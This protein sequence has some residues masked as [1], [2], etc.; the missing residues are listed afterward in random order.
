MIFLFRFSSSI[1][2]ELFK[3]SSHL[4]KVGDTAFDFKLL[5]Q[6]RNKELLSNYIGKIVVLYFFPRSDTPG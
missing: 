6:S 5:N 1:V 4:P 2:L 3:N